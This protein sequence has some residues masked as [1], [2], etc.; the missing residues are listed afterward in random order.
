MFLSWIIHGLYNHQ[1]QLKTSDSLHK[2]TQSSC[3]TKK[4]KKLYN[5]IYANI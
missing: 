2:T 3:G 5:K 1:I 4:N